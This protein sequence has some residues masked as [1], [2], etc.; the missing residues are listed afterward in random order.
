MRSMSGRLSDLIP[1]GKTLRDLS[2]EEQEKVIAEWRRLL[3]E[4][5]ARFKKRR[6]N[7]RRIARGLRPLPVNTTGNGKAVPRSREANVLLELPMNGARE[8]ILD[9]N[10]DVVLEAVQK[11]A[12]DTALGPTIA[13]DLADSS[14]RLR[15]DVLVKDD[16]DVYRQ[17]AKVLDVIE[18][19]TGLH[20]ESSRSSIDGR[21]VSTP[22]LAA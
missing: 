2:P 11:H 14:I 7:L 13:L 22:A 6:E 1:E 16:A 8:E 17:I 9:I 15:F 10:S 4:Y 19:Q 21:A 3:P 5:R 20:F 18:K 12:A